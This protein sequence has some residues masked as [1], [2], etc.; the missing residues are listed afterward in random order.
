MSEDSSLA[1]SLIHGDPLLRLQ[2]RFGLVPTGGLGVGRRALALALLT[3]LPLVVWAL[4]SG[5]ALPGA[6]GEPLLRHFGVQVR[7]LVAIPLFVLAEGV[8]HGITLRL[9]PHFVRSGLVTEADRP[10]FR[11]V[12]V[13][14]ARLRDRTL[15][16]AM[17]LGLAIA[18]QALGAGE[19]HEVV[20]AEDSP[21]PSSFGFGAWW[22]TWIARPI[23]LGLL[24]GWLWRLVLLCV[25]F[26]RIARLDLALVPTHADG[27]GGLGF[28]ESTP[29][30]FSPVVF[31][32]SAVLA[33]RW[34]H[35]VLYHGVH[36][37]ELRMQMIAVVVLAALLFLAPLALWLPTLRAC[38]RRALLD[39]GILVGE[40]GRLVRRRWILH[41]P[42]ADAELL[43]APEIGPVADTLSLYEAVRKM[44]TVPIGR[45]SLLAIVLAAGIPMLPVL[46]IEIPIKELLL[47][48]L[49][50][51]A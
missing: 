8:A 5:H 12:L 6:A 49:K 13:G 44:R 23:F 37:Q 40:H 30:M 48:L 2:R 26:R 36:V 3:W 24:L 32:I 43:G 17:I 38:K 28:L 27:A 16:W 7:C 46:T 29:V 45:S 47:G 15:P 10:R 1:I 42:V 22:F 50:T 31:G 21:L 19:S 39:Y 35:D 9:L 4:L 20:W 25:L 51:L 33:S 11:E 14:V 34:A 41:E 18:A